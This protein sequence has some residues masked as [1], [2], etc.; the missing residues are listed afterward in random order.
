VVGTAAAATRAVRGLQVEHVASAVTAAGEPANELEPARAEKRWARHDLVV[1]LDASLDDLGPKASA[2]VE[3][4]FSTW[5]A[6]SP[7]LPALHL[8]PTAGE[9]PS[10]GPDGRNTVSQ[11]PISI[12]GHEQDLAITVTYR[13][14][15][16]GELHE[17]DIV[18]NSR[19]SWAALEAST[20][21]CDGSFD[22]RSVLTHE[23][24]HFLGLRDETEQSS[25]TMYF[26]THQCETHKRQ[27]A[28][29]DVAAVRNLYQDGAWSPA[30]GISREVRATVAS[31][32]S[33][34]RARLS[35]GLLPVLAL[36]ALTIRRRRRTAPSCRP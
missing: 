31:F 33:L 24:G 28:P 32:A 20:P 35:S 21:L 18:L 26:V 19:Y 12:P 8:K 30:L 34:P 3:Q 36:A 25:S 4:A 13:D 29:E 14:A 27:L 15:Q 23:V 11:G 17:A 16:S 9:D 10:R 7:T 1:Y 6:A 5:L 22:L 2:A